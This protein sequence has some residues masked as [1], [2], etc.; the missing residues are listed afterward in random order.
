MAGGT[1]VAGTNCGKDWAVIAGDASSPT[2]GPRR[3][4]GRALGP[5][6]AIWRC[7]ARSAKTCSAVNDPGRDVKPAVG[8][9][10]VA[11]IVQQMPTYVVNTIVD[12]HSTYC[13]LPCD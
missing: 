3:V 7:R 13:S 8:P 12:E 10:V 5:D 4:E 6:G 2:D 11:K 9:V 1:D